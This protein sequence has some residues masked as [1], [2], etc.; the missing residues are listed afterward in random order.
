MKRILI[1]DNIRSAH[2]V[3]S[4][5]RSADAVSI[6]HVYLVGVTPLPIDRFGRKSGDITKASLGAED[7]LSWS[8]SEDIHVLIANLRERGV[9]IVALEQSEKSIS[10]K[11]YVVRKEKSVALIVGNEVLGID[12]SVLEKVD[13]ILEIPMQGMKESLNVSV[14]GGIALYHLFGQ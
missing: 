10:Y 11:E 8:Y 2:N 3:G 9:Y 13:S 4:L 12:S 1:L 6:E 7:A 14:A 5:L